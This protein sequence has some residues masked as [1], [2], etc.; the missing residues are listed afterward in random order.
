MS[1]YLIVYLTYIKVN[2]LT[3]P[4]ATKFQFT[5]WYNQSHLA[6]YLLATKNCVMLAK[7]TL[8]GE[9]H[10]LHLS[11]FV[12]QNKEMVVMLVIDQQIADCIIG[13]GSTRGRLNN[14]LGLGYIDNGFNTNPLPVQN[15]LKQNF[16]DWSIFFKKFQNGPIFS[17]KY[18]QTKFSAVQNFRDR[19]TYVLSN[20]ILFVNCIYLCLNNL[21]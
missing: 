9:K 13:Q 7:I 3:T 1:D 16:Q 2:Q 18:T 11:L 14:Q 15:K 4:L 8:V 17:E 10:L 19:I 12:K 5:L 20:E 6:C 21:Q